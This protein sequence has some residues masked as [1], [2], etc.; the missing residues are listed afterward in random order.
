MQSWI[1]SWISNCPSLSHL[2]SPSP[3]LLPSPSL[4]Q[5]KHKRRR[6]VKC[7]APQQHPA[8]K[9]WLNNMPSPRKKTQKRPREYQEVVVPQRR[10]RARRNADRI[11]EGWQVEIELLEVESCNNCGGNVPTLEPSVRY[12][13]DLYHNDCTCLRQLRQGRL[14]SFLDWDSG[15]SWVRRT[16]ETIRKSLQGS[17]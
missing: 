7:P 16:Q 9:Q 14:R 13:R 17:R 15:H 11:A 10:R 6:P 1:Q 2:S 3:S 12:E 5:S 8:P 4:G